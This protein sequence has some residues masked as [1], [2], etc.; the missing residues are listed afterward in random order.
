MKFQCK[1]FLSALALGLKRSFAYLSNSSLVTNR[2]VG[3]T[4]YFKLDEFLYAQ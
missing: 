4:Y 2:N 3:I 1:H